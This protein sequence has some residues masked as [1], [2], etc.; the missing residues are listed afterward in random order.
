MISEIP[1]SVRDRGVSVSNIRGFNFDKIN[2]DE[3]FKKKDSGNIEGAGIYINN[4]AIGLGAGNFG[5][6]GQV[7]TSNGSGNPAT[8]ENQIEGGGL[9]D[10]TPNSG[11]SGD[12]IRIISNNFKSNWFLDQGDIYNDGA[13]HGKG[14]TAFSGGVLYHSFLVLFS[15]LLLMQSKFLI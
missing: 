13:T 8:W 1:Y 3:T 7:L 5:T 15:I 11:N 10:L 2:I 14:L 12:I 9:Y 4:G 6:S